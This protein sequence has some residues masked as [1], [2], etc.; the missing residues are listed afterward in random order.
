MK[1]VSILHST[2][3][4]YMKQLRIL[5]IA[6]CLGAVMNMAVLYFISDIRT[7]EIAESNSSYTLIAASGI[8][9]LI[10][11]IKRFISSRIQNLKTSDSLESKLNI[12]RSS[13]IIEFAVV[14]GPLLLCAVLSFIFKD[15]MFMVLAGLLLVYLVFIM[16]RKEVIENYNFYKI[17]EKKYFSGNKT[18]LAIQESL[19]N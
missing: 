11:L 10:F 8:V 6:M 14:E 19:E 15:S 1:P 13:K 9:V 16:P 4:D 7:D 12:I 17:E 5:H 2:Y 18:V 3:E